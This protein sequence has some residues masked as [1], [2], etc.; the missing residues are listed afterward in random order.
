MIDSGTEMYF[1]KSTTFSSYCPKNHPTR[2]SILS[3][4]SEKLPLTFL[5]HLFWYSCRVSIM[6]SSDVLFTFLTI[7]TFNLM[8]AIWEFSW[9]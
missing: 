1:D 9:W 6:V 5:K 7:Q 8:K 3:S 2:A 4:L